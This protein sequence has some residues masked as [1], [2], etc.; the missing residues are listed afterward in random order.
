MSSLVAKLLPL[1][2]VWYASICLA[3]SV[4]DEYSISNLD[5]D[6]FTSEK[7]V[8]HLFQMWKKETER[9][10][11]TL[12]EQTARFQ[13]FKSN[14]KYI[15]EKNAK[16][17]SPNDSRLGLN[18]FSDMSYEEFS[19]IYLHE[20]EE[21]IMEGNNSKRILNDAS[22]RNAPSSWD[23][24][25]KGAVTYVKDQGRCGS[26]W[27]FSATGAIEGITRIVSKWLP[28]LSEQ[29]L[30]SCVTS[31]KGCQGGWYGKAFDYVMNNG[32]ITSEA[33]YPYRAD[34]SACNYAW[35]R[36]RITT[37]DGYAYWRDSPISDSSLRCFV[38]NQPVSVSL[39]ASAEFKSYAGGIFKGDDCLHIRSCKHNHAVLIV[40][41]GSS[42]DGRDYW[43]V[44][45]SWGPNWGKQ[46]Y[47]LIKRNTGSTRGVCNI[48]CSGAYPTKGNNEIPA[49]KLATSI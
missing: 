22:C 8:F 36:N 44:K 37:I 16:R 4:H 43:I 42:R 47:I 14:L 1:F 23:W 39:Y 11:Q 10:Y 18:K 28:D 2:L 19:K 3:S 31:N 9:E 40:G 13:I 34:G 33:H 21:P 24:R 20:I 6:M 41:Y 38:Y 30:I 35:A 27:A 12:E 45:N 49:L 25:T 46:G 7:E 5:L 26:C 15:R 29:Q 48:N 17:K 32:G